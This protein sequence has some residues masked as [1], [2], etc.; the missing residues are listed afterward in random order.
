MTKP[1]VQKLSCN[2]WPRGKAV[3]SQRRSGKYGPFVLGGGR[4]TS[5]TRNE[6]C[7]MSGCK[8]ATYVGDH[9]ETLQIFSVDGQKR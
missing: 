8:I 3:I 7:S 9:I 5:N 4:G 1:I 2:S 6:H